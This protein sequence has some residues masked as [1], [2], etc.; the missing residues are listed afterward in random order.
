VRRTFDDLIAEADAAPVQGWDFSWLDGRATEARPSWGY[1][2][3]VA[4]RMG[5]ASTALDVDTG[6]G[7]VLSCLPFRAG[8]FDLVISR[9][10]V[11]TSWA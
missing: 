9:H 5:T 8:V 6:G 4:E 11:D 1:P 3:L 7:E 10:P 2:R